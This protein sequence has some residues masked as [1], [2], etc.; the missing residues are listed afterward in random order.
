MLRLPSRALSVVVLVGTTATTLAAQ[1]STASAPTPIPR[2]ADGRPDLQGNWSNATMTPVERPAGLARAL[3]R[4]QAAAREK[5]RADLKEAT[6]AKIDPNRP[7][8][9]KGGDGSTGGIR[10]EK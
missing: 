4:E 2:T 6:D 8:P 7:A 1:A 9:P 5:G 10:S 3:T